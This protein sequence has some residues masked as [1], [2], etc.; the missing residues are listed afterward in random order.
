MSTLHERLSVIESALQNLQTLDI[1]EPPRRQSLDHRFDKTAPEVDA[2]P[3]PTPAQERPNPFDLPGKSQFYDTIAAKFGLG[4]L[5]HENFNEYVVYNA[6]VTNLRVCPVH[7][8]DTGKYYYIEHRFYLPS[9]PGVVLR[10]GTDKEGECLG[11]ANIPLAG[12]NT[13]GV[14]NFKERPHEI[15]WEHL[16]STGFWTHMRYEFEHEIPGRER[17]IFQWIRTRNNI[18]D[19]QGDL[20]LIQKEKE[21]NILAEYVGKG[22]LKWKKRGR[23][24]IK[25]IAAFGEEWEQVVLLTWSSVIELSRRRARIRRY[26]PTH[27][28]HG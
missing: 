6:W 16:R 28:I 26:S 19:D 13:F 24:R 1:A 22:L 9:T 10:H 21:D 12:R 20:V 25:N 2:A 3:F 23:L 4:I 7:L 15:V 8:T 5:N 17:R 14:G 11:V 18:L 27:I